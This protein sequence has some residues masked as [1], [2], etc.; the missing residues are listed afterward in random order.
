MGGP[1]EHAADSA[2]AWMMLAALAAAELLGM[3]LWFSATAVT[4]ALTAAFALDAAQ[5]AWLTM[6]VQAG[7]VVATLATAVFNL[8]DAVNPRT[9]MAWG[10]VAGAAANVAALAVS[11]PLALIASR[12]AT[13]AALAWVY[14]PAMKVAAGWFRH[15]RGFALGLLVG[16]LTLGKAMPHLVTALFA[17]DWRTPMVVTSALALGGAG[18]ATRV[19]RDGPLLPPRSRF[20]LGA[21]GRVFAVRDVRLATAG[22]LGHMWELY[23]MW[24]WVAAFAAASLAAWGASAPTRDAA[25]VAFVAIASGAAGCAAAGRLADRLGKARV[26]RLAMVGSGLCCLATPL[27]YG[28]HP[29]WLLL[30]VAIWGVAVVADS[31]QFS[32]LV[33]ERAPADAVGTALTLQTSLGFL[34][35]MATIDALPRVAAVVGWQYASWMLALGPLAGWL[36]MRSLEARAQSSG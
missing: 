7:F 4:P 25:A 21:V 2:G 12:L 20:D 27:V 6:A 23:A 28:R 17:T 1:P 18:L 32:A 31:A 8:A 30:L 34:L 22:Y 26:A 35:T 9:L 10:C 3:S 16:A 15:H 13:G 33:S 19:V 24:A 36:A 5:A 11:S 29:A 14:P